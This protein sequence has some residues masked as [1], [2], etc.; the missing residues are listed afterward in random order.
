MEI[1]AKVRAFLADRGAH[2]LLVT[3][4]DNYI[5]ITEGRHNHV[6]R[7][8]PTGVGTLVITGDRVEISADSSDC[9]RLHTEENPLGASAA[10]VPW[11]ESMEGFLQHYVQGERFLSD[12]GVA[13]TEN[14]QAA[15]V[16][17]R[18]QLTAGEIA[19]YRRAGSLCAE[20]VESVC[21]GAVP[22]DTETEIARRVCRQATALGI[23]PDCVLVGS[24]ERI[25]AYRHPMPTDKPIEKSLM[26]VLGG[27]LRGLFI[28]MT[29]IVYFGEVPDQ[30]LEK[31]RKNQEIFAKMQL[32]MRDGLTYR[33]YFG[34]VQQYYR[35]AGYPDDWQ[36]H[37]QG[38]PTGY[39]CR[40]FVVAPQTPGK[41][42]AGQAYAWNPT[43][44]GT[45]CEETTILGGDGV[46][47]LT[48]TQSWP[49]RMVETSMGELDVA[50][51][52]L[53]P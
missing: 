1:L 17:L 45:K 41:L 27:E 28:S 44:T 30:L 52:L 18:L 43:L 23:N 20:V 16:D 42:R 12:T 22:G 37:H 38:G 50:D 2:G 53:K 34:M 24:D 35:Q 51:I 15:L 11:Y 47:I 48:R 7:D 31:H 33:D 19:A 3:R 8:S 25:A 46:E 36:L 29:R 4:R 26:V 5:W 9:A 13:G 40:E 6:M 49:V 10:P 14:V 32:A 21:R 39:A